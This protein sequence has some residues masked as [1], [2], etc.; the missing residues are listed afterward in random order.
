MLYLTLELV[1]GTSTV[2]RMTTSKNPNPAKLH[3]V[4]YKLTD[5]SSLISVTKVIEN[6]LIFSCNNVL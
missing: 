5:N 2:G 6:E 1:P 4:V 3:T